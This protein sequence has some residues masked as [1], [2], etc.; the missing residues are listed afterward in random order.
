MERIFIDREWCIDYVLLAL[1][2]I[3]N[4][5]NK[6]MTIIDFTK[7]IETQFEIYADENEMKNTRERLLQKLENRKIILTD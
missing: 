5:A 3:D 6:E 4:S 7:E 1:N 2:C